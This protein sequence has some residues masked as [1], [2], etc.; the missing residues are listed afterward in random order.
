[1]RQGRENDGGGLVKKKKM[2]GGCGDC[3][4]G[5]RNGSET[6]EPPIIVPQECR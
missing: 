5:V 6:A 3:R 1:M 4:R 2:L